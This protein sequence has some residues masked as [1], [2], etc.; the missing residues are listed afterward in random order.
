METN[1]EIKVTSW[2]G[3]ARM[4]SALKVKQPPLI[5]FCAQAKVKENVEINDKFIITFCGLNMK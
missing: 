2:L 1:G 3:E 5:Q 4:T